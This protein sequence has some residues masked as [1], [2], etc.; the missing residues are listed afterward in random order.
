MSRLYNITAFP[1]I[2][3]PN[4]QIKK[5]YSWTNLCR[6]LGAERKPVEKQKQGCWSPATFDGKRAVENVQS[7]SCLVVD[8]DHKIKFGS[9]AA[10]CLIHRMQSYLHSSVSHNPYKEDRFRLVLPLAEDAPKEEWIY[11]HRALKKW[12]HMVFRDDGFDESA[13]DS[14]RAYYVGYRTEYWCENSFPG[15]ILDWRGMAQDAK[16]AHIAERKRIEAEREQRLIEMRRRDKQLGQNRSYSDKRKIMY[17]KLHNDADERMK[18]ARFLVATIKDGDAGARAIGWNCP[19]CGKN[20]CTYFFID[21]VRRDNNLFAP[22]SYCMHR[23]NCGYKRSL[24][25]LAEINGYL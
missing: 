14:S 13:K 24:G 10:M 6:F 16:R 22:L 8:I 20:D 23:N 18:F 7:L 25:Y 12:W 3:Q 21:P 9:V 17:D 4:R 2:L 5:C 11:Y 19:Q 15:K 1:N